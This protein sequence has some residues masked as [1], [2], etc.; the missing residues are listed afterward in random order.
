[1][2][3]EDVVERDRCGKRG[4]CQTSGSV[5]D[6]HQSFS[7]PPIHE[8]AGRKRQDEERERRG[9]LRDP[10]LGRRAR[11]REDEERDRD[12]GDPC[13]EIGEDLPAPEQVEV[14]VAAE[15]ETFALRAYSP[16]GLN[17]F[18]LV[19]TRTLFVSR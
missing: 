16:N 1:V 19:E 8:R 14:A 7:V 3:K 15:R 17:G 18:G 13:P 9:E 2:G 12:V 11:D 5:A 10:G 6:D 4:V